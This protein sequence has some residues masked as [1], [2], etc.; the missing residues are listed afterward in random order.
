MKSSKAIATAL[1]LVLGLVA[2]HAAPGQAASEADIDLMF[3]VPEFVADLTVSPAAIDMGEE[4]DVAHNFEANIESNTYWDLFLHTTGLLDADGELI[5]ARDLYYGFGFSAI[6][7]EPTRVT[8]GF[9]DGYFLQSVKVRRT[10][11]NDEPDP[12][13]YTGKLI[14]S[15]VK[16]Y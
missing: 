7:K 11:S 14:F 2:M 1:V 5:R 12:G 6:P 3:T 13:D 15:V 10:A 4:L 16:R 8:G 9:E